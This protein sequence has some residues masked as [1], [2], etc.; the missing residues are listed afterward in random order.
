MEEYLIA[1]LLWIPTVLMKLGR[2]CCTILRTSMIVQEMEEVIPHWTEAK[3]VAIT[4]HGHCTLEDINDYPDGCIIWLKYF[5]VGCVSPVK[6]KRN[7]TQRERNECMGC[8]I[9]VIFIF[10]SR[11]IT[12]FVHL[13]LTLYWILSGSRWHMPISPSK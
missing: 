2:I 12:Q 6:M 9:Q 10:W 8:S 11:L 1:S 3:A 13:C 5:S 4:A 7:E